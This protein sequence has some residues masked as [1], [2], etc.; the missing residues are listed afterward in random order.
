M[1][2]DLEVNSSNYAAT[3]GSG[4]G[5]PGA[6]LG[7]GRIALSTPNTVYI[8]PTGV[9]AASGSS[10]LNV[11]LG[12]GSGGSVSIVAK[13]LSQGGRIEAVGGMASAGEGEGYSDGAAGGGGRIAISVSS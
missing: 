8:Y 2:N 13:T 4:G 1:Y 6:G 7:G 12:A 9:V 3:F 5:A 10:A 11:T